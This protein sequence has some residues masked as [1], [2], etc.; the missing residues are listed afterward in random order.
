MTLSRFGFLSVRP[1]KTRRAFI[2]GL[3]GIWAIPAVFFIRMIRPWVWFRIGILA[4]ERSGHF[5]PDSAIY[6]ALQS[7]ESTRWRTVY[8]FWFPR[9]TSNEQWAKMV[10]RQLCVR[11]WVKYLF[12]FNRLIPGG[13]VHGLPS[14]NGSRDIHGVVAKSKVSFAFTP[15]EIDA[16]QAWLRKRG[17][18]DGERFV[19]LLARDSAYL[20][21]LVPRTDA[22][23]ADP[24]GYH[25]YRD[26]DID[27]YVESVQALVDRGYWVIRMGKT[28]HKPLALRHPRVIDYPFAT[29]QEDLLDVWLSANCSFFISCGTGIDAIPT[30]YGVPVIF[31]NT[32]PIGH[33]FS[34]ADNLCV[35]KHLRWKESGRLLTLREHLNQANYLATAQYDQTGILIE[36][37]SPTEITEVIMELE[38]RITGNWLDTDEAKILQSRFWHLL[39]TWSE[40]DRYHGYLHPNARVGT[41]WLKSMGPAFLD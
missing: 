24:W 38:Q 20:S 1:G 4:S 16:A 30:A 5:V 17:W 13:T 9:P 6:L 7:L 2:Y 40:F 37:L 39:R 15:E 29:D 25:S 12:V 33:L 28:M 8:L 21:S 32:L 26:T 3:N 22:K 19:C 11:W 27:T 14:A 34:F 36:D 10:C 35:P 31:L 23:N 41:A 18:R